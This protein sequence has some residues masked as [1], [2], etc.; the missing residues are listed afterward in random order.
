M[1]HGW[2]LIVWVHKSWGSHWQRVAHSHLPDRLGSC[3]DRHRP[4]LPNPV[5]T[6]SI[7]HNLSIL[8]FHSFSFEWML[9]VV[10]KQDR[11]RLVWWRNPRHLDTCWHDL[12]LTSQSWL[13]Q[14]R[15]SK[16]GWFSL[17]RWNMMEPYQVISSISSFTSHLILKYFEFWKNSSCLYAKLLKS[18]SR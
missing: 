11:L 6:Y 15:D 8:G 16:K 7:Y 5:K 13:R 14:A 2:F 4:L 18:L 12:N 1:I 9:L 3:Q 10:L 17:N